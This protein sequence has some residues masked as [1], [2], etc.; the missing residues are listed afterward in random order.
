MLFAAVFLLGLLLGAGLGACLLVKLIIAELFAP[1]AT[2]VRK[3]VKRRPL[4]KP[5]SSGLF[6]STHKETPMAWPV[7]GRAFSPTAFKAYVERLTWNGGFRP[8]FLAL[9]NTAAPSLA[10][11]PA[12][13]TDKHI[14]NLESYYRDQRNWNGGPHLFIDDTQIWVFN[15]LTKIGVHSPSWNRVALGIEMLG[16][17]ETE[18]FTEGRGA[19]VRANTVAAMAA[20]NTKLGL[21][22]GGFRFHI[23][24][25]A[26]NH[27]CPGKLA[28]AEREALIAE[29]EAAMA[30]DAAPAAAVVT[31]SAAINPA[32]LVSRTIRDANVLKIVGGSLGAGAA[33]KGVHEANTPVPLAPPIP[34]ISLDAVGDQ[35]GIL[36]K[37][38]EGMGS[39]SKLVVQ[40]YWV[41]GIIAGLALW[42]YGRRIIAWYI[43]DIR[44]GKREPVFKITKKLIG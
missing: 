40:H 29:I 38:L 28:R 25:K 12:G 21:S 9:H 11:R 43:D 2:P 24:D 17:Y 3:P 31:A 41:A 32:D 26:S 42:W 33:A 4:F 7:V 8:Q 6:E 36:Q 27:A 23:E 1:T 34:D 20:L 19:K 37:V 5:A 39:L 10:Q 13:L 16:D 30:A 44:T 18:S 22:A 14:K 15:D 35:I